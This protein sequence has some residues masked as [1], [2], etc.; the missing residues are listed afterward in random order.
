[1]IKKVMKVDSDDGFRYY[2][3]AF[4]N[5][6]YNIRWKCVSSDGGLSTNFHDAKLSRTIE[7]ATQVFGNFFKK[8]TI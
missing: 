7:S 3:V 6:W 4:K 2:F 5:H 1:M 8:N